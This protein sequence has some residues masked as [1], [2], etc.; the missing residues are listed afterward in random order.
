M[1]ILDR[2]FAPLALAQFL[3]GL[4][5]NFLK[6]ALV[7]LVLANLPGIAGES[8]VALYSAL[9]MIPMIFMSGLG[10]QLLR[11]K[12]RLPLMGA[13]VISAFAIAT[14]M[15]EKIVYSRWIGANED[16]ADG[17]QVE[18]N[19]CHRT[20]EP[21]KMDARSVIADGAGRNDVRRSRLHSGGSGVFGIHLAR[22]AESVFHAP[23]F[24]V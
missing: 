8:A 7:F 15:L 3:T 24:V 17:A 6:N 19:R 16:Y 20:R 2:R 22:S 21:W 18:G 1:L 12:Y 9:F 5:S 10:G 13:S 4:N 11:P 23:K 14:G